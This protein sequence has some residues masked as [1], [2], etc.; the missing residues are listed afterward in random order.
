MDRQTAPTFV[1][2]SINEVWRAHRHGVPIYLRITPADHRGAG[3]VAA[4]LAWMRALVDHG[5][6]VVRP[7][8][9]VSGDLLV[10]AHWEGQPAVIAAFTAAPGRPARKPHDYATKVLV[11]WAELLSDLHRHAHADDGGNCQDNGHG[12]SRPTWDE[13]R[14]FAIARSALEPETILAQQALQRLEAWMRHLPRP[15][16]AF[17]LTHADLHLGNLSVDE[18]AGDSVTAFDFDDSCHHWF[19]HDVAVAVTSIRK[20]A[21]ESPDDVDGVATEREFLGAYF[22]VAELP[23]VWRT[24]LPAFIAYRIALSACWASHS[25]TRGELEDD[26][27]AWYQRSLPWWLAQ[28]T[29]A[30]AEIDRAMEA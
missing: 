9:T 8:Q 22:R 25:F 4:E 24:R 10:R 19:I 1:R 3:E 30:R 16:D 13:D 21:W 26:M 20:A 12:E 23:E 6:R 2:R 27:L 5:V 11:S 7:L 29:A 28:L 18:A 17:G 15:R 14:V